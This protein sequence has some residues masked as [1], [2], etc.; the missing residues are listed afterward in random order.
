[1]AVPLRLITGILCA[2][3]LGC[4]EESERCLPVAVDD[5]FASK[6]RVC[7]NQALEFGAPMSL[8]SWDDTQAPSTRS[9]V[10]VWEETSRRIHMDTRP[11]PPT[12]LPPLSAA[13]LEILDQW[14]AAGAP[15]GECSE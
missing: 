9:G 10:A 4:G 2:L 15:P 14:I 13:E 1:M 12:G 3:V 8:D 5:V 6:C 7:H 11:M